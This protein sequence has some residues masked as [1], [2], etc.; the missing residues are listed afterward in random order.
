V[1]EGCG[2][3]PGPSPHQESGELAHPPDTQE[4]RGK[5]GGG[6][7]RRRLRGRPGARR[8]LCAQG[9]GGRSRQVGPRRALPL[10][11]PARPP[12]RGRGRGQ[13]GLSV[14]PPS[15]RS[16]SAPRRAPP[17]PPPPPLR[18][19]R[20]PRLPM[21]TD[22]PQP[23][24]ASPD[25]PHDPWY[26]PARPGPACP[27]RVRPGPANM[28]DP[29]RAG[30]SP[31]LGPAPPAPWRPALTRALCVSA[32]PAARCSS[33]D[34]VGRPRRVSQPRD[35]PPAPA[36]PPCTPCGTPSPDA[37]ARPR[38]PLTPGALV[39][40]SAPRPG[41]PESAARSASAHGPARVGEQLWGV[42]GGLR[43]HR[44]GRAGP[45]GPAS[46]SSNSARTCGSNFC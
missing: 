1:G 9:G 26:G 10:A 12:E 41:D 21:E 29:G 11:V 23:G 38:A 20:R 31:G 45:P 34:S 6:S 42:G 16:S 17:P 43:G 32:P 37:P 46:G 8:A 15:P 35:R 39:P 7:Q 40:S 4:P 13:H 36:P 3:A 25:S 44:G 22:A 27:A 19:P 24:L 33:E 14:R 2:R 28:A 30:A 18:C 5:W